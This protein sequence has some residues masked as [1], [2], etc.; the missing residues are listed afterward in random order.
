MGRHVVAQLSDFPVGERRIVEVE[1]RSIGVFNLHGGFYALRN[2]C[3]HQ[4]APLCLGRVLRKV[5]SPRPFAV[6]FSP[7]GQVVKCPWHGWEFDVRTGRS[8]FNPHRVRV[9]SYEVSVEPLEED[10]SVD[11]YQ[12]TVE[13]GLVVVH[14]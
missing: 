13:D 2:S 7:D 8:V 10:P 12:V 6:E 3:P 1:G 4:G 9:R 5:E 14:V 11:T